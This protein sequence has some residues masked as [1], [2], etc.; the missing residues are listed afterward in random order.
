[1]VRQSL[2]TATS[3]NDNKP[4]NNNSLLN[5]ADM[6]A[7]DESISSDNYII[8]NDASNKNTSNNKH[9]ATNTS[10]TNHIVSFFQDIDSHN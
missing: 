10:D 7:T 4:S 8:D 3:T 5:L 1:M 9:I 2:N 6:N